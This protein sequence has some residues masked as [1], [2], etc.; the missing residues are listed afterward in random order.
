MLEFG[1]GVK[2]RMSKTEISKG[3]GV[4][5]GKTSSRAVLPSLLLENTQNV[6]ALV[7]HLEGLGWGCFDQSA[8][9]PD[10]APRAEVSQHT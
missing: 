4:V 10:P 9:A 7:W 1:K 3:G 2:I 5:K 8:A 6:I